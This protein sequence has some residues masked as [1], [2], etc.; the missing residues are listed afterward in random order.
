MELTSLLF[1]LF[2][3]AF[4]CI[5]ATYR[6]ERIIELLKQIRKNQ[7]TMHPELT[8]TCSSP[9]QT[10]EVYDW[11]VDKKKSKKKVKK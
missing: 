5:Y 10:T 4:F 1:N 3:I 2:L 7:H 6:I 9:K 11:G 8:V